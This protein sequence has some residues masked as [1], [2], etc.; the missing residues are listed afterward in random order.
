M[1]AS[2]QHMTELIDTILGQGLHS[3]WLYGSVVLDDYRLGWSDIDFI[4]FSKYPV[5]ME[6]AS[7]LLPLRQDLSA[8]F[9]H[10]PYYRSFE[11]VIVSFQE[12][13]TGQYTRL[14]Y[15]GTSGQRITDRFRLDPFSRWELV[16]H[17][18]QVYGAPVEGLFMEPTRAELID[19][20]RQHCEGIRRYAVET[21]E[22]LYS[23][24]WLL[25]I[26]RCVYTLRYGGVISKTRAGAWALEEHLF[27]EE[28]ALQKTLL[29]RKDPL[30]YRD[31]PDIRS[32]LRSLGPTV[33]RYADVLER[34]LKK[35][36]MDTDKLP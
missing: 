33:Q 16:R 15:W 22:R 3:L 31:R 27:A 12:Y 36:G 35:V 26:A 29:I 5:S 9:P 18:K 25:D 17:G 7:R 24:G 23:C 10:N 13:L 28:A 6:Q 34:E 20:V 19:A 1:E 8:R 30:A 11:G 2:L 21:D 32:W 14:V 4:A